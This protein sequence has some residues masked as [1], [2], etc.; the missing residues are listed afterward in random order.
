[1]PHLNQNSRKIPGLFRG[2]PQRFA[3]GAAVLLATFALSVSNPAEA[4]I[5][6]GSMRFTLDTDVFT[7]GGVSIEPDGG[8]SSDSMVVGFGPNLLGNSR[9]NFDMPTTGL[10]FGYALS[11]QF[12]LG[13]R[14]GL[15]FDVVD[16]EG[17]ND[18]VRYFGISLAPGIT[19]LP[20][21]DRNKLFVALSPVFQA[22]KAKNENS[23]S[24]AILG[25]FSAGVGGLLFMSNS[26][27]VDA[28][29]FFE[30]RF[31][32]LKQNNLGLQGEGSLQDLR[33]VLRLGLSLWR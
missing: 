16:G 14:T 5:R 22:N 12:L 17:N 11:P 3:L 31:G 10:G 28:G 7:I 21:G 13:L 33:G 4:Q 30:G 29:F 2:L 26:V 23:R 1:M 27:S 15:G 24:R 19:W 20:V 9:T 32:G 18:K 6:D 25:G 8:N